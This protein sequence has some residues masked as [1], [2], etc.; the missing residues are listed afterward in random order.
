M[1][2]VK[3]YNKL[4]HSDT[5]TALLDCDFFEIKSLIVMMEETH[6]YAKFNSF[7]EFAHFFKRIQP[8]HRCYH[9]VISGS[10][11]QKVFFDIDVK[12][13]EEHESVKLA[14]LS[15]I[16]V[17]RHLLPQIK[18]KDILVFNSNGIDKLSYHII[19]DRWCFVDYQNNRAFFD[20]VMSM[21]PE[22]YRNYCD[23]GLYTSLHNFRIFN[24]HKSG[25]ERVKILDSLSTWI[26]DI[27]EKF[28]EFETFMNILGASLIS[29]TSYCKLLPN[30]YIPIDKFYN[31]NDI[32]LNDDELNLV[33]EHCKYFEKS[34]VLPYKIKHAKG[35][36]LELE[37]TQPSFCKIC[38]RSHENQHPFI[39]ISVSSGDIKW[40]CRRKR[41]SE[42]YVGILIGNMNSAPQDVKI[43]EKKNKTTN[44]QKNVQKT[45]ISLENTSVTLNNPSTYNYTYS[46]IDL[47]T[48][49]F[50]ELLVDAIK[51]SSN[52]S[53]KKENEYQEI[54]YDMF[55]NYTD[56][57]LPLIDKVKKPRKKAPQKEKKVKESIDLDHF[58]KSIY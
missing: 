57:L 7:R 38:Q 29:N 26:Y 49:I 45:V 42:G 20:Q 55:A 43:I 22:K 8:I 2:G 52:P 6:S 33:I 9:E 4:T 34:Q 12:N 1:N 37:R 10:L 5:F 15:I 40:Y 51:S 18:A 53:S 11:P 46:D 35:T 23:G 14:I 36:L 41:D 39:T 27:K 31:E 58:M 47:N 16:S 48:N 44:T 13:V 50:D 56:Q 19:V 17:V 25:S 21:L 3:W 28:N 54:P 32:V 24:N 30:F